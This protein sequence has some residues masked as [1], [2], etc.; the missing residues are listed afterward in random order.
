[1]EG[2][3]QNSTRAKGMGRGVRSTSPCIRG[4]Y[5]FQRPEKARACLVV[6]TE[7]IGHEPA[8]NGVSIV[9]TEKL[10]IYVT[11]IANRSTNPV[12][13]TFSTTPGS[14]CELFILSEHTAVPRFLIR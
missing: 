6:K 4:R 12:I 10:L 3:Q 5:P 2:K 8:P 14:D 1:M 9:L 13:A 11:V 7:S